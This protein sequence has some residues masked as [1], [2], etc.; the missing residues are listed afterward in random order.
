MGFLGLSIPP[1]ALLSPLL[2]LAN[3]IAHGHDAVLREALAL[4]DRAGE[5]DAVVDAWVG[6]SFTDRVLILEIERGREL[7]GDLDAVLAD[8]DLVGANAV[9]GTGGADGSSMGI[10]GDVERHKFVDVRTRGDHQS[11]VVTPGDESV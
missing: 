1:D 2:G 9:Y 11:Y 10:V 4:A 5:Y 3:A 8:H 7:P 6:K